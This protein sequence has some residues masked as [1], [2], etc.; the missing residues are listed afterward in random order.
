MP[1][2]EYQ[3]NLTSLASG[4]RGEQLHLG[5]D[6]GI[7]DV[8]APGVDART[9]GRRPADL[10]ER[11]VDRVPR[12][13]LLRL[14]RQRL[15]LLREL[16]RLGLGQQAA[17]PAQHAVVAGGRIRGNARAPRTPSR[18]RRQQGLEPHGGVQHAGE[19][20]HDPPRLCGRPPFGPMPGAHHGRVIRR[21]GAQLGQLLHPGVG[22]PG[23]GV[24]AP[25]VLADQ[26][27]DQRHG[28]CRRLPSGDVHDVGRLPAALPRLVQRG[29][30]GPGG[31]PVLVDRGIP[32]RERGRQRLGQLGV[33][34]CAVP[35]EFGEPRV[36]RHVEHAAR[37]RRR[38][39]ARRCGRRGLST[40]DV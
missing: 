4:D 8:H 39:A 9:V 37:R 19:L 40:A 32:R 29:E 20:E 3:T 12:H 14:G 34:E 25:R 10:E 6:V 30:Q 17:D 5:A 15:G 22:R 28:A 11:G 35:Q 2:L 26:C 1:R 16:G 33:G 36:V 27:H 7:A 18:R 31:D 23:R 13:Q 21:E 24:A 38:W